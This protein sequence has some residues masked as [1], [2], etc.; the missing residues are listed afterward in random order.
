[1]DEEAKIEGATIGIDLG[2][3][4]S[5]V[6]VWQDGRVHIVANE[7]GNRTTPSCVGFSGVERLVGDAAK[8]QAILNPPNTV[9]NVKHLIGRPFTDKTVQ[10]HKKR[11]P[12]AVTEGPDG[13]PRVRVH[14][15]GLRKSFRA[16]EISAMVL[17]KMKAAA[18]K[19]LGTEVRHAVVT[20]PAY[21]D[22]RKR[23]ATRE[24]ARIAG[25][26][27]TRIIS[28]PIA[29]AIAYGLNQNVGESLIALLFDLGGATFDVT[30][31]EICDGIFGMITIDGDNDL[32]GE[33]ID[34]ILVEY[35]C[36]DFKRRFHKDLRTSKRALRRLRV[37]AERAKHTLSSAKEAEIEV[38][39][40]FDGVDFCHTLTRARFNQL[41]APVFERL[42]A[43]VERVLKVE[44]TPK[45]AVDA[46][47]L[48]GGSTHIP[49]V[50]H[51][52]SEFFGGKTLCKDI[53][54]DEVVAYGATIRAAI[55]SGDITGRFSP[56]EV[57]RMLREAKG[58]H[59]AH[60][61]DRERVDAKNALKNYLSQL[62]STIQTTDASS[63]AG[64]A[65]AFSSADVDRVQGVVTG[66]M[67]WL[68]VHGTATNVEFE[69]KQREVEG[70]VGLVLSRAA[71]SNSTNGGNCAG[72]SSAVTGA[73]SSELVE[74]P[75]EPTEEHTEATEDH[76]E[77]V[78][79]CS[80]GASIPSIE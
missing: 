64:G 9:F 56:A 43:P 48:V 73:S 12:F 57:E 67:E 36:A 45:S 35:L 1:M 68:D 29:A 4:H 80:T 37:A 11:F 44:G 19:H 53:N 63:G 74:G 6:G 51:M 59:T 78:E 30:L 47:V 17:G 60:A 70:I 8:N 79:D 24:A 61:A 55:D 13:E 66:A 34:S 77:P 46:V 58:H 28:E 7:V 5:C 16:E 39:S 27:V 40:L 69:E 10:E 42:L 21:F 72:S 49:E 52:L 23:H 20:V 33:D 50:Q 65:G 31:M 62:R 71:T 32:G 41:A 14:Y 75:R 2:T 76:T 15:K 22:D 25:L 3:T 26:N 18:E 38:E 54:P